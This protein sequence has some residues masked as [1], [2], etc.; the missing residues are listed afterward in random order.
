MID[1]NVWINAFTHR[2][3]TIAGRSSDRREEAAHR[4]LAQISE[5]R[6]FVVHTS[7]HILRNVLA[8]LLERGSSQQDA[9]DRQAEV[10]DLVRLGGGTCTVNPP[11]VSNL[12]VEWEDR[13][14]HDAAIATDSAFLVTGDKNFAACR[15]AAITAPGGVLIYRPAEFSRMLRERLRSIGGGAPESEAT[16]LR[17]EQGLAPEVNRAPPQFARPRRNLH[18]STAH[19]HRGSGWSAG[20]EL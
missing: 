13:R 18:A 5:D 4:V 8:K 20:R 17:P 16:I 2:S 7:D 11:E 10:L 6:R 19:R 1:V 14:V 15:A 9:H 12:E 3:N